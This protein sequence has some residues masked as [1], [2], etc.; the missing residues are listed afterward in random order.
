VNAKHPKGAGV[1]KEATSFRVRDSGTWRKAV[2]NAD[3]ARFARRCNDADLRL[4]FTRPDVEPVIAQ[5][6]VKPR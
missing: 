5:V 6:L 2:F 3:D 4:C 1:F